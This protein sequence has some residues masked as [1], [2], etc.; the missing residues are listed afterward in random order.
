MKKIQI[1]L[2]LLLIAILFFKSVTYSQIKIV[3]KPT[4]LCEVKT[5]LSWEAEIDKLDESYYAFIFRDN[6]Y[7]RIISTKILR[8]SKEQL[9]E[10]RD[11]FLAA[12]SASIGDQIRIRD[13]MIVKERGIGVNYYTLYF[14]NGYCNLYSKNVKKIVETISNL[15]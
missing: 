4:V 10:L 6:T 11:G 8:L 1:K 2:V 15:K 3:K 5:G 9:L 12:D 7:E 14:D 13:Y